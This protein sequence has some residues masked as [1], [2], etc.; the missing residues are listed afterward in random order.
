MNKIEH[1]LTCLA[2]EGGEIVWTAAKAGRFGLDH[3]WP[4]KNET[5]RR[6][7]ERELADILGVAQELGL[8]IRHRDINRKRL[9]LR[10][11]MD[12]ARDLGT[13]E[14]ESSVSLKI[15]DMCWCRKDPKKG[16]H[17][18]GCAKERRRRGLA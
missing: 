17:E 11:M 4:E 8:V 18:R 10:K 3:V 7:L 5:N 15:L 1:L 2:E 14:S 9:K 13:L 6:I 16:V 12:F